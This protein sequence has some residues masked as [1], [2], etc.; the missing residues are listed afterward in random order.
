MHVQ[1]TFRGETGLNQ[2]SHLILCAYVKHSSKSYVCA[3]CHSSQRF[4]I[5]E[6]SVLY[7]SSALTFDPLILT[8][9]IGIE[10]KCDVVVTPQGA[11]TQEILETLRDCHVTHIQVIIFILNSHNG[12]H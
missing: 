9:L 4:G 6:K 1:A 8:I 3:Y 2:V 7:C 5:T 11:T 12:A 10:A